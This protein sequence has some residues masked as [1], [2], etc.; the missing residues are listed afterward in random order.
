MYWIYMVYT[1][2]TI[3]FLFS[4]IFFYCSSFCVLKYLLADEFDILLLMFHGKKNKSPYVC[5]VHFFSTFI[6]RQN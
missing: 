4:S 3:Q 5:I 1:S 2:P 6:L